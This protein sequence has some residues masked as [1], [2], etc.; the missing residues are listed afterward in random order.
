MISIVIPL[1]N[2]IKFTRECLKTLPQ[3]SNG[4][5]LILVDDGSTDGTR[6]WVETL[7][8]KFLFHDKNYGIHRAWNN[9][10]KMA[11]GEFICISNSD[12]LF[13]KDWDIPLINNLNDSVWVTSPYHTN[14]DVPLDFPKGKHRTTNGLAVLGSCF[15]A[16]RDLFD[17]IGFFPEQ[18]RLFYGDNW[19]CDIV[20]KKGGVIKQIENSYVHH[21]VSRSVGKA[22]SQMEI[23]H[24]I[25]IANRKNFGL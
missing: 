20:D 15:M 8:H 18:M 11:S 25:Y 3:T 14:G 9:G 6:E 5:E 16:R 17:K 10:I 24:N 19:L 13:T 7:G 12:I 23:D 1:F 4:Y 21:H 2:A 22:I